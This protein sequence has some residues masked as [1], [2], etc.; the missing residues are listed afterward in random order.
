ML[1][2]TIVLVMDTLALLCKI[3]SRVNLCINLFLAYFIQG[4]GLA[5]WIHIDVW[6]RRVIVKYK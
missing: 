2:K 4:T 6:T 1:G 3:C 5:D